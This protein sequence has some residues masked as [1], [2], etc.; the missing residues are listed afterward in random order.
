MATLFS[1]QISRHSF[2]PLL[3][4]G[5]GDAEAHTFNVPD[6]RGRS[7]IGSGTG[8]GLTERVVGQTEGQESH[9][10]TIAEMPNHSHPY[11]DIFFSDNSGFDP[12]VSETPV[13]NNFGQGSDSNHDNVGLQIPRTTDAVGNGQAFNMMPPCAVITYII[14]M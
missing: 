2:K 7:V 13:P 3:E 12:G 5:G 4:D 8:P 1:R 14:K 6:L 10:L 11:W 9:A